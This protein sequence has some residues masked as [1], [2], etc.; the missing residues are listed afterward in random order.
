M[1][2][3]SVEIV[4]MSNNACCLVCREPRPA[5]QNVRAGAAALLPRGPS[6]PPLWRLRPS[7]ARPAS[8]QPGRPTPERRGGEAGPLQGVSARPGGPQESQRR[9]RTPEVRGLHCG[10]SGGGRL[11]HC[12]HISRDSSSEVRTGGRTGRTVS[13]LFTFRQRVVQGNI[14]RPGG[15]TLS[16]EDLEAYGLSI[17][18]SSD[19]GLPSSHKAPAPAFSPSVQF[20][21]PGP[22]SGTSIQPNKQV[23]PSSVAPSQFAPAGQLQI[24]NISQAPPASTAVTQQ[25]FGQTN[26]FSPATFRPA[27]NTPALPFSSQFSPPNTINSKQPFQF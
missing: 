5:C 18:V 1:S 2:V 20:V 8:L 15:R 24:V 27:S 9:L 17:E 14:R 13:S 25:Q 23:T 12:P 19:F 10:Q 4:R 7:P 6:P 22:E 21:S 11:Q 26:Q 3:E 16:Q